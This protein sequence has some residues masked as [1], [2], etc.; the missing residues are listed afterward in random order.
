MAET[1]CKVSRK[2]YSSKNRKLFSQLGCWGGKESPLGSDCVQGENKKIQSNWGRR[3]V[4]GGKKA[5]NRRLRFWKR[6]LVDSGCKLMPVR[7]QIPKRSGGSCSPV[8]VAKIWK[9]RRGW[10]ARI[11]ADSL[12][13]LPTSDAFFSGIRRILSR[14]SPWRIH[15]LNSSVRLNWSSPAV[16]SPGGPTQP[17]RIDL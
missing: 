12:P 8:P 17:S 1:L 5:K 11:A 4:E 15:Q 16:A 7:N 2:S 13:S 9:R 14:P 6:G 10:E 3:F